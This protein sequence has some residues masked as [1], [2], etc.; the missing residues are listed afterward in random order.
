MPGLHSPFGAFH[1]TVLTLV[2]GPA[3]ASAAAPSS[4]KPLRTARMTRSHTCSKAPVEVVAGS[5]SAKLSLARCDGTAIPASVDQLSTF[6]RPASAAKTKPVDPRVAERLEVVAD[7]FRKEGQVPRIILTPGNKPRTSGSYHASGRALDF[8]IDGVANDAIVA[9]C[10][11]IPDTGCGFYP[12]S[13]FVHVDVRDAGAGHVAWIDAS[14]PGEAPRYVSVW[15]QPADE[16]PAAHEKA[17]L[18][19]EADKASVDKTKGAGKDHRV[20][21]AGPVLVGE[22]TLPPLPAAAQFAPLEPAKT[23]DH[24]TVEKAVEK[25]VEKT[26]DKTPSDE[27]TSAPVSPKKTAHA[28]GKKRHHKLT[29][30]L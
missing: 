21:S 20:A 29:H 28:K 6:A 5:E 19:A 23:D 11:T 13:G 2:L 8:R 12:N 14:H 9:F 1:V 16:S 24:A 15:P 30:T 18:H 10:K 4:A 27:A 7:H 25:A 17:D 3:V 22:P 26:A